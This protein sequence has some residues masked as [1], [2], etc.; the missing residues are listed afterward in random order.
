MSARI[1]P[2]NILMV[3]SM[4]SSGRTRRESI[5]SPNEDITTIDVV[6]GIRR[7]KVIRSNNEVDGASQSKAKHTMKSRWWKVKTMMGLATK[8]LTTGMF[9]GCL[10]PSD[11]PRILDQWLKLCGLNKIP[12][13]DMQKVADEFDKR[14]KQALTKEVKAKL[15]LSNCHLRDEHLQLLCRVLASNPKIVSLDISNNPAISS[16]LMFC[17]VDASRQLAGENC[18]S[19]SIMLEEVIWEPISLTFPANS[20]ALL[21]NIC[22]TQ[23]SALLEEMISKAS[24]E[25]KTVNVKNWTRRLYDKYGMPESLDDES[26]FKIFQKIVNKGRQD[27]QRHCST[28]SSS[29]S[30][31]IIEELQSIVLAGLVQ[32][33]VLPPPLP[34]N[35]ADDST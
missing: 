16:T 3:G 13:V 24:A 23:P 7:N 30:T 4:S 20:S 32:D 9:E 14:S 35:N 33:G 6:D 29:S 5:T 26:C 19:R 2:S 8:K 1:P 10:D 17:Q 11:F 12:I 15:N 31:S 22:D 18:L 34:D 27:Y 25:L 21:D 28:T